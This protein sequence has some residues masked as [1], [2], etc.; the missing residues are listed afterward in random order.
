MSVHTLRRILQQLGPPY[1]D[2]VGGAVN[3][4][5]FTADF[6]ATRVHV[7]KMGFGGQ[8]WPYFQPDYKGPAAYLE[9]LRRPHTPL[10]K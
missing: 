1:S 10:A 3:E 9:N 5:L 6:S 4:Q 2:S 8:I 7:T